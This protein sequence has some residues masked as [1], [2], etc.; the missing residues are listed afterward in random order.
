[1]APPT[2]SATK[3]ITLLPG[4]CAV[5]RLV[6]L[7]HQPLAVGLGG[8]VGL[9]GRG[10]RSTA[11]RDGDVDQQRRELRAP[12]GVAAHRQRAQRVAVVALAARDEVALRCGWPIST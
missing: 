5:D 3:A 4:R 10:I 8:L 2:V 7:A 9:R 11:T 1:V 12:P 6:Q